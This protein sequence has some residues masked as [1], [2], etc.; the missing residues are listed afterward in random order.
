[1]GD[2]IKNIFSANVT[3]IPN[4]FFQKYLADVN[5]DYL[6]VYLYILWKDENDLSIEKIAD[7]LTLTENDVEKAFKFWRKQKYFAT[8]KVAKKEEKS[9]EEFDNKSN[10]N[11]DKKVIFKELLFYAEK[12]F[13]QTISPKQKE[14]IEYMFFELDLPVDVIEYLIE[15][16]CELDKTNARYMV[17]VADDWKDKN[18]KSAKEVKKMQKDFSLKK[19][20]KKVLQ[21]S[22]KKIVKSNFS[23]RKN[24]YR[25][26]ENKKMMSGTSGW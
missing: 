18:I 3:C 5:P 15:Y 13:P 23:E 1:M 14:A 10:N 19:N 4:D 22:N 21:N 11:E 26:I 7:E 9:K 8:N 17:A 16:C 24:N 6:R 25:E 20:E 2:E 12:M